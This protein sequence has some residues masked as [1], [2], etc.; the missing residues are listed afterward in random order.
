MIP[1]SLTTNYLPLWTFFRSGLS[2]FMPIFQI[3]II[4][5]YGHFSDLD[6]LPS[7]TFS[8]L[9]Y[10]PSWTFSDLDYLTYAHF[11]RS[12]L[13]SKIFQI[14]IIF[15]HAHFEIWIIFLYAHFSDLD[16]LPYCPFFGSGLSSLLPIFQIWI[17][18]LIA[19]FSDLD[20]LP[21]CTS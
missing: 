12:G 5:L 1:P 8:D 3:W 11:F 14:W 7:C 21:S 6:Y 20:Y 16:Y 19:H 9:D 17:I 13:S 2:S 10:L 4:F 15:L 18:F